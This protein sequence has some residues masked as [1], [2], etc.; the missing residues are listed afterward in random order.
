MTQFL[1]WLG[2]FFGSWKFWIVVPPWDVGVRVRLGRVAASL[3]PGPHWRVPLL[4]DVTLVNTRLRIASTPPVMMQ[5]GTSVMVHVVSATIGFRIADPMLAMARFEQPVVAVLGYAQAEIV[6]LLSAE[7]CCDALTRFFA[8]SG[9]E[10]EFV[11]YI[12]DAKV[13]AFRLISADWKVAD[14]MH[15]AVEGRY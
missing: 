14:G 5:N 13:R 8:G 4:D 6:R 9:V 10:I 3:G 7:G 12:E 2:R 11:R 1:E 15:G